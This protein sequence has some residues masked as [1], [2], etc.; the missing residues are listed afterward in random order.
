LVTA[1]YYEE[2]WQTGKG[3]SPSD[4]E[5]SPQEKDL[6]APHLRP[7]VDCLD[8]G[9]GDG[10]RYGRFL[11]ECGVQYRGFDVSTEA[12]AKARS[13]GLNAELLTADG[14]TSLPDDCCDLAVCFEV[15]EHLLEPQLAL[16]EIARVLRP[17]GVLLA[18]VPNAAYWFQRCE[19]LATGFFN[20]GGSPLTARTKPW[21]DPHIR[22][23]SPKLFHRF[24]LENGFQRIEILPSPFTLAWLPYI[25]RKQRL[26]AFAEVISK[27]LGWL[28]RVEPGLFSSRLFARAYLS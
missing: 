14:K 20:P 15:F 16:A 18:S 17:K 3:W 10:V 23:F 19:F 1:K 4:G 13:L 6:F 2:Y 8:Y 9:C 25:Y 5:L 21:A 22:F 7:G 24:F 27:P 11:R 12:V 28:S 26:R